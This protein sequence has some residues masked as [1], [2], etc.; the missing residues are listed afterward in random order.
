MLSEEELLA[1]CVLLLFAGHETTTNLIANGVLALLEHPDQLERLQ[2]DAALLPSAIEELIRYDGPVQATARCATVNLEL[3]GSSI[4]PG[5][6]LLLVL[7]AA[8][9][10]PDQFPNPDRLDVGRRDNRH[11]GFGHGIHFCL[12]APL[13]RLEGQ[14][15]L[16]A[17]L[18]R[19]P[20]LRLGDEPP[21]RKP[22]FFLRGLSSLPVLIG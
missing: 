6:F 10:D 17:L 5:E 22:D 8:N 15:A 16:G 20:R 9:R 19:F 4:Q 11:L 18:Q 14:L 7:G 13:A 12:G 1:T 2:H 3:H 21:V